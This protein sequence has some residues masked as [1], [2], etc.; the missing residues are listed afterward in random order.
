M[1]QLN[2]S[3]TRPHTDG[4]RQLHELNGILLHYNCVGEI[5]ISK[6]LPLPVPDVTVNPRK[7]VFVKYVLA[8]IAL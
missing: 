6:V 2:C 3:T 4:L 7:D 8:E 5:T 1:R